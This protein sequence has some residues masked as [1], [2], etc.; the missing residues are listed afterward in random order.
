MPPKRRM[1]NKCTA[2]GRIIEGDRCSRC[3]E[4]QQFND[5]VF[6]VSV[7]PSTLEYQ[8]TMKD[9]CPEDETCSCCFRISTIFYPLQF[10]FI[11]SNTIIR[12]HFTPLLNSDRVTLCHICNNYLNPLSPQFKHTR[13]FKFAW[14]SVFWQLLKD[15]TTT[16]FWK[17]LPFEMRISWLN[18]TACN[19]ETFFKNIDLV[20]KPVVFDV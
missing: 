15:Q 14:P 17:F 20:T 13:H 10:T 19:E 3:E 2:C 4:T 8:S 9:I 18:K 16:T 7:L 12:R 1:L 5:D 6:E 11:Q